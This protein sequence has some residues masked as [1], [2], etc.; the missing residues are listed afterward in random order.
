MTPLDYAKILAAYAMTT[1][2]H[3]QGHFNEAG[4][5]GI[6]IDLDMK[7]LVEVYQPRDADE[8]ARMAGAGYR[9]QD[10]VAEAFDGTEMGQPMRDANWAH[11]AAYLSGLPN[12]MSGK[13]VPGGDLGELDRSKG[14]HFGREALAISGLWDYMK[15][16]NP[17]MLKNHNVRFW[18]DQKTGTPGLEYEVKW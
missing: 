3:T 13:L 7:N 4:R 6:P 5:L 18:Q 2:A 9:M 1:G 15:A 11:K 10:R 14:K 16:R 12:A 8:Q 17:E